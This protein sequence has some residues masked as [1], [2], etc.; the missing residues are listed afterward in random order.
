MVERASQPHTDGT[1]Q[2][3]SERVPYARAIPEP[4]SGPL[5]TAAGVTLLA[6]ALVTNF[7]VLLC[8]IVILVVGLVVWFSSVF[9]QERLEEIPAR[10]H[11]APDADFRVPM[12]PEHGRPAYPAE[13]HPTRVGIRGGLL[14][15]VAM[16]VVA[17]AWGLVTHGSVWLPINLLVG[18]AIPGIEGSDLETLRSF[19]AGW[20]AA[21]VAIHALLSIAVG[22]LYSTALPIAANH[23]LLAGA[24]A[25]PL[26]MSGLV[27]ATVSTVNPALQEY[28]SWPW[29]IASQVAFGVACGG[30]TSS[31]ARV[32][33]MRGRSLAQRLGIERGGEP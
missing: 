19:H 21:A 24:I 17:C 18:V 11:A 10:A 22:A 25:I 5:I 33:A 31:R 1:P 12:R 23:P 27:W 9:P 28:I 32:P 3:G 7:W 16:A 26:I 15:G 20:F 4:T 6:A 8:G 29:F 14:G 2:D 13:V 30:W